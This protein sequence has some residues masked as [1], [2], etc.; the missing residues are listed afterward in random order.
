[1]GIKFSEAQIVVL[2]RGVILPP[3]IR[4]DIMIINQLQTRSAILHYSDLIKSLRRQWK[5][6]SF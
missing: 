1:M 6:E 3:G 4:P 5:E 2:A